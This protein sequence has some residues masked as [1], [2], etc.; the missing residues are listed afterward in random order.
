LN[1][2]G[3]GSSG[4]VAEARLA[5]CEFKGRAEALA[6]VLEWAQEIED[7]PVTRG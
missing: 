1:E 5:H 3:L 4:D 7:E 2:G 6:E